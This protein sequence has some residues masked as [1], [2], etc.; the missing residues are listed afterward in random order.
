MYNE[1]DISQSVQIGKVIS[2]IK[3]MVETLKTMTRRAAMEHDKITADDFASNEDFYMNHLNV[4]YISNFS[5]G[6]AYSPEN[7]DR[8]SIEKFLDMLILTCDVYEGLH[9]SARHGFIE[10][11]SYFSEYVD[12]FREALKEAVKYGQTNIVRFLIDNGRY[13]RIDDD[14]IDH[15]MLIAASYGYTSIVALCIDRGA[16]DTNRALLYAVS[17]DRLDVVKYIVE[18]YDVGVEIALKKASA[19]GSMKTLRYFLEYDLNLE[20]ITMMAM[21]ATKHDNLYVVLLLLEK[22]F[23][24]VRLLYIT[25]YYDNSEICRFLLENF[26]FNDDVLENVSIYAMRRGSNT[27]EII[28]PHHR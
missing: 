25:V 5:D 15:T 27:I 16:R 12:D 7:K 10:G 17:R 3:K 6:S 2:I 20:I 14:Y 21:N 1:W 23:D 26:Q 4:K 19:I 13:K 22:G 9:Y 24:I 8:A 28:N 11:I 18:N